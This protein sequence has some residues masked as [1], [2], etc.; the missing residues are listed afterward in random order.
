MFGFLQDLGHETETCIQD[1]C[2]FMFDTPLFHSS[3]LT[4][5]YMEYI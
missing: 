5:A 2:H 4:I 1:H 3:L